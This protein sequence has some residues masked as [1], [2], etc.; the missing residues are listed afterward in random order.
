MKFLQLE[1]MDLEP[2]NSENVSIII[3]VITLFAYDKIIL[4]TSRR[5]RRARR[6][7]ALT[8]VNIAVLT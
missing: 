1:C 4:K 6:T 3:I 8:A 5:A 2:V 7:R